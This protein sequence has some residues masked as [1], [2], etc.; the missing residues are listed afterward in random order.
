VGRC[1]SGVKNHHRKRRSSWPAYTR[2][3]FIIIIIIIRVVMIL[4]III[5]STSIRISRIIM[6]AFRSNWVSE[7][8]A[9]IMAGMYKIHVYHYMYRCLDLDR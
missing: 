5:S 1:L 9:E 7:Q 6:D 2:Y 3:G 8:A 4:M